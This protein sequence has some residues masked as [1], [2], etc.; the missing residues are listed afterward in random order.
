MSDKHM[1]QK[2]TTTTQEAPSLFQPPAVEQLAGNAAA[3]EESGLE[4]QSSPIFGN[5]E[6][7]M[8]LGMVLDG[9]A[10]MLAAPGRL[11]LIGMKQDDIVMLTDVVKLGATMIAENRSYLVTAPSKLPEELASRLEKVE[12]MYDMESGVM[13]LKPDISP[14]TPGGQAIVLHEIAHAL[15]MNDPA[16]AVTLME[17]K[18]E[19]TKLGE[20]IS[21]VEDVDVVLQD[22]VLVMRE[23]FI[24]HRAEALAIAGLKDR[25]DL[26]EGNDRGTGHAR[27]VD[28]VDDTAKRG[29]SYDAAHKDWDESLRS[30]LVDESAFEIAKYTAAVDAFVTGDGT[31]PPSLLTFRS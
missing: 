18:E 17:S 11:E 19:I 2:S 26:D 1:R 23:E 15:R 21:S 30:H 24:A 3:Q 6:G 31:V 25:R 10:P 4:V 7:A 5:V 22:H 9:V 29:A 14:T 20:D 8:I 28:R 16:V 12:A 27:A 13:Y